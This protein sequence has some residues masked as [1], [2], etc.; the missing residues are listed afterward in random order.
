MDTI[1]SG[2]ESLGG[3]APE[4]S[5]SA[6]LATY[7]WLRSYISRVPCDSE[8][9]VTEEGLAKATG[10]SR[11]PVREAL[12]RAEAAGLIRIVP[13]KGAFI[14]RV[15]EA[16]IVEVIQARLMVEEWAIEQS[17]DRHARVLDE[18]NALLDRQRD[19]VADDVAFIDIDREFHRIYVEAAENRLALSFYEGLRERQLRMGLRAVRDSVTRN[20]RVLGEHEAIVK[21][22]V[23]GDVS[24]AK[25]AVRRHLQSTLSALTVMSNSAKGVGASQYSEQPV[26]FSLD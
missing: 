14:P 5:P 24:E 25:D 3:H 21:A 7:E 15:S 2:F 20:S 19:S 1:T 9:F 11:T 4:S 8:L 6:R 16:E 12:L 18:M 13:K 17:R 10:Y 26:Y 22:M 23:K